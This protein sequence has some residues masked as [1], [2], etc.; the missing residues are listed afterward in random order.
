MDGESAGGHFRNQMNFSL[1]S[2]VTWFQ[3]APHRLYR[4][5]AAAILLFFFLSSA[6]GF[7]QTNDNLFFPSELKKLSV[8]ELMNLDVISVSKRREKL[9]EAASAIQ[10]ITGEEIQRSGAT[11]LPEALRLASNLEVAQVDS[12]QWAISARGFNTTLANKLLVMIDGRTVYTPLYAGVYWDVQNVLLDDLDRIEVVS[13][14]GGTLWG[15]NAVNGVINVISKPAQETQGMLVTGGG[16]SFVQDFGGV[17]YGDHVGTNFFYRMYGQRMDHNPAVFANGQDATNS[18]DMTQGG[19]RADW[20][21]CDV[22]MFTLQGDFYSG[23]FEQPAR[24]L[25]AGTPVVGESTVDGQNVLGRWTRTISEES[26]FTL[27][28]YF[29]RTWRDVPNTSAIAAIPNFFAQEIVT[30]DIDFQHQF[31]LGNRQ[32][33]VWGAG[34]RLMD[35]DSKNSPGL[36]FIPPNKDLQLFSGFIQD[37]IT[38]VPDRIRFVIGTKLEHNDYSGFEVQPSIRIAWTPDERQTLWGAVSRAVR[39]PSRIDGEAT[40]PI[41]MGTNF[42]SLVTNPGFDSE[43]LIAYEAGYRIQPL[44]TLAFSVSGYYNDY[45]SLRSVDLTSTN[46]LV[47]ANNFEGQTWGIETYITYQ[48]FQ[49]WRLRGGY[50]YL[51]KHLTPTSPSAAPSIRE[52]NDPEHQ[53]SLQS[54]VNLPANFQLDVTARYVSSLPSPVVPDYFTFDVRFAWQFRNWEFAVV[55]Q[56]LWDSQHAEFGAAGTRLEI[57][58]SVYGKVTWHFW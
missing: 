22:N 3:I 1:R 5:I 26:E 40:A 32:S 29:D 23:T 46:T 44:K 6:A 25:P 56:N 45:N 58:R 42:T 20:Y 51:H 8:E 50:N 38:L 57:P 12:H 11:T 14:P 55:G 27:Q 17:R 48:P 41:A 2:R 21:P 49:W 47:L 13:G 18:W 19:F 34:Y 36:S 39:S 4:H 9:S 16:G 7:A 37:E 28:M 35:I 31:P 10:V 52:G 30:Y 53:F 24:V 15:A 54:L 43:K 33:I